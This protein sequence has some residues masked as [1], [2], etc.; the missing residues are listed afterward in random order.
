MVRELI[1][2]G[3]RSVLPLGADDAEVK[4]IEIETN[5]KE[6][7]QRIR[8]GK[9]FNSKESKFFQ[10]D[11]A[12]NKEE[13]LEKY[14]VRDE[15]F[16]IFGW[17]TYDLKLCGSELLIYALIFCFNYFRNSL[18]C[19]SQEYIGARCGC[20]RKTVNKVLRSL[21]E[22]DLLL[23]VIVC[24]KGVNG[25][26]YTAYVCKRCINRLSMGLGVLPYVYKECDSHLHLPMTA[27]VHKDD[28]NRAFID[29]W[30]KSREI[31]L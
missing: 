16:K 29:S 6:E 18:F 10:T 24:L 20:T 5:S 25:V 11:L 14:N 13:L 12:T 30:R 31:L 19:G 7:G 23:K 22:K 17:M 8:L 9:Y 2:K 3:D 26:E 27:V 4:V 15:D 28:K 21:V 1:N